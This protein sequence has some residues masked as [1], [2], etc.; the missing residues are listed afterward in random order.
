MV[1]IYRYAVSCLLFK[2]DSFFTLC[3]NARITSFYLFSSK[4]ML[5]F[6]RV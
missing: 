3:F 2:F 4:W 1:G 5:I 6:I